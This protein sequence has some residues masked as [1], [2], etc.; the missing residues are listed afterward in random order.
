[1]TCLIIKAIKAL[2][3]WKECDKVEQS[4]SP[5]VHPHAHWFSS[6]LSG[7]VFPVYRDTLKKN[8]ID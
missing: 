3:K 4:G 5:A 7:L 8:F 1:M 2:C 6:Y